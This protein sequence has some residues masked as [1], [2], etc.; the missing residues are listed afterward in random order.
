MNTML[1]ISLLCVSFQ[2]CEISVFASD[3]TGL[4]NA[5]AKKSNLVAGCGYVGEQIGGCVNAA[6]VSPLFFGLIVGVT[7]P[8]LGSVGAAAGASIG[9]VALG[10]TGA[11]IHGIKGARQGGLVGAG[12]G[13]ARG[14]QDGVKLGGSKGASL[15]LKLG[16]AAAVFRGFAGVGEA[17]YSD[18]LS[19]GAQLGRQAGEAVG[20]VAAR[21]VDGYKN[22]DDRTKAIFAGSTFAVISMLS[23]ASKK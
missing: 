22:S 4:G 15:G 17:L 18:N 8:V 3:Q 9:A 7:T 5:V 1:K 10:S 23:A 16:V 14:A 11:V 12:F 21:G 20:A 13:V 2:M 19:T 6:I